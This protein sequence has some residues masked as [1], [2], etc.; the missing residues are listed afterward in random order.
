MRLKIIFIFCTETGSFLI[1][2]FKRY[3]QANFRLLKSAYEKKVFGNQ[4]WAPLKIFCCKILVFQITST[5]AVDINYKTASLNNVSGLQL[6]INQSIC[7]FCKRLFHRD[8]WFMTRKPINFNICE[9]KFNNHQDFEHLAIDAITSMYFSCRW[10]ESGKHY[11]HRHDGANAFAPI[12][13]HLAKSIN[14]LNWANI[15][16]TPD[17]CTSRPKEHF[18]VI[19]HVRSCMDSNSSPSPRRRCTNNNSV[20]CGQK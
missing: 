8:C 15:P 18:C 1:I 7:L 5:L 14:W 9:V 3:W 6:Q 4:F 10:H 13:I 11:L 2:I 19:A 17:A 12:F 16:N 20:C